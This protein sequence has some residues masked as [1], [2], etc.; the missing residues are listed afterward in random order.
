[1]K[2]RNLHN[3]AC[4]AACL[5]TS[6]MGCSQSRPAT[7]AVGGEVDEASTASARN[8]EVTVFG[9]LPSQGSSEYV[10]RSATAL[11]QHT[12]T[13]EGNDYDPDVSKDGRLVVFASTRHS[14]QANLYYKTVDGVTVTQL[15][16][17]AAADVQ[18]VFSPDGQQVA[19]ASNRAGNWDI[20][21]VGLDGRQPIQV[22]DSPAD[23]LHPSWSPDGRRLTYC[24]L[25]D[26][27]QWELWVVDA[28]AGGRKRF[29]GYGLFP[30]WSPTGEKILFQ[31]GRERGNRWFS[32]W[33]LDLVNDEPLHP[34][35]VAS[36]AEFALITPAWSADAS[37]IAFVAVTPAM[38]SASGSTAGISQADIWIVDADG[39]GRV[40]LTDGQTA[41]FAP[42][43]SPDGR[44]FFT[45]SRG[46]AENV[47][48]LMPMNVSIESG[49]VASGKTAA[50]ESEPPLDG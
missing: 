30:A 50:F 32:L 22:T 8:Q 43:F 29:I 9:E 15:T 48:S 33:T 23:E 39:R 10:S 28:A 1:M 17:D 45:S 3:I 34:T 19:F 5:A 21:V 49:D 16:A 46:G 13:E 41:N 18:P 42:A 27:G 38:A 2:A 7:T 24:S 12:F 47:W 26:R 44:L 37:R 36:S 4:G 31:R 6:I 35:E 40:R 11:L 25:P 14:E 20:W